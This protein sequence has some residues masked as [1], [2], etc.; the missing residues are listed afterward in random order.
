[1]TLLNRLTVD[2]DVPFRFAKRDLRY[3]TSREAAWDA[4]ISVIAGIPLIPIAA[5]LE[6]AAGIARRGGT[7]VVHASPTR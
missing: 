4:L 3:M 5:A 2:R 6:S 1:L 7:V